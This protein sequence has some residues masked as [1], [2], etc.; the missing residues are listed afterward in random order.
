MKQTDVLIIGGS[1][2]GIVAA[3]TAKSFHPNKK[4]MVVRKDS[5]VL[6][7]C[8][9]PYIFGTLEESRKN[10]MPD[11]MLADAGVELKIDE[12]LSFDSKKKTCLTS[13]NTEISFEKLVL[14]TGS[15]PVKPG[16]LEGADLENVFTIPKDRAYL[17]D[18]KARLENHSRIAVVG[19][20]FIGVELADE[21]AKT[22]K[23]VSII[24]I[25][26]HILSAAFDKEFALKAEET[27]AARGIELQTGK[28]IKKILGSGKVE[29]VALSTGE[30]LEAD[31]VILSLGY[32]PNSGLAKK[33]GLEINEMG[34]I[35]VNEYMRT[36]NP[37]I[38]AVGDCAEKYSF[39]TR[40]LKGTMLASTSC[41]EARIAGMNL[42]K[43][44]TVRSFGGTISIYCTCIGEK[45]FGAAGVT[46]NLA[47]QRGFEI[48]TGTFEGVDRH[49]G[50]L[51][52]AQPQAVK[53]I[54][55]RD[56][57]T[58]LGGEVAGGKSTGEFTNLIG[59]IIQTRMTVDA[60]LTAQIGTHPLLTASPAAYPVIKAAESI[61]KQR[62]NSV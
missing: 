22:G 36:E 54:A 15:T 27:V 17:D 5:Q 21:L 44:S 25:E 28:G 55:A 7:P 42:Y 39:V 45:A 8:G 62:R 40:T 9:I 32:R 50:T 30:E 33:S 16:W 3:T 34:F 10:I 41:A 43:L 11:E 6:V 53:L 58:V 31:A 19:G 20:G 61:A 57:G 26:P 37:D 4:V 13:D 60:V 51:P 52:D 47:N 35:K 12:V 46:E 48:L 29:K 18:I 38:F 59:L 1:A 14:A 2:A 23:K 24:E 56:S 49:P